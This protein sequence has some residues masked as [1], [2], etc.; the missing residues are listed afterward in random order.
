MDTG[1]L[2]SSPLGTIQLDAIKA[3]E[4][5]K[6]SKISTATLRQINICAYKKKLS[7]DEY[8]YQEGKDGL[9][10]I[11]RRSDNLEPVQFNYI[12]PNEPIFKPS[13]GELSSFATKLNT[14]SSII[15]SS[16]GI[17]LIYSMFI[18]GGV[19]PTAIMLE[20]M[21]FSRHAERNLL[22]SYVSKGNSIQYEGI[23]KPKYCIISSESDKEIMGSSK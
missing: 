1:N 6:K 21:G 19:I 14:L 3:Y 7:K 20:H 10:S 23:S 2:V 18:W 11:L 22:T 4:D 12:K 17:V 9:M 16:K 15:K 8:E 5:R 13:Y